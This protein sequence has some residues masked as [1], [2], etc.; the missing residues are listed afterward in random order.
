MLMRFLFY[1][2]AVAP[3][4]WPALPFD[5]CTKPARHRCGQDFAAESRLR[6]LRL[7]SAAVI[8]TSVF[9][10]QPV[11]CADKAGDD[12]NV[13]AGAYRSGRME[14]SAETFS[15]FLKDYPE[16][17]RAGIARLYFG[18]SLSSL[19]RYKE[20][21]EQF[22]TYISQQPRAP[23]VADARYRL[24]ECSYYL[25]DFA[26]AKTQL[27]EYLKEH[28]KHALHEWAMLFLA[29]SLQELGES[30]TASELLSQLLKDS[31]TTKLL[32]DAQFSLA[33][34]LESQQQQ[35]Q[36]VEVYRQISDDQASMLAPRALA[37]IGTIYFNRRQYEEASA[38]YDQV[39][40]RFADNPIAASAQFN[41]GLALF[42]AEKFDAAILRFDRLPQNSPSRPLALQLKAT[43]LLK[44]GRTDES[45]QALTDAVQAAGET[46]LATDL[47]I[48]LGQ[49]ERETKQYAAAAQVFEDIATR[50]PMDLRS[51]EALFNG[52]EL[53]LDL[54][55]VD[56]A[57]KLWRRL[58][59]GFSDQSKQNREQVL[60]GR[61]L[62][63]RG[64]RDGAISV[65]RG[66]VGDVALSADSPRPLFVGRYYLIRA[67][68]EAE[69]HSEVI[70]LARPAAVL[71]KE[72]NWRDLRGI[73]ALAA[74]SSLRQE[75]FADAV[76]FA[77]EFLGDESA[78]EQRAEVTA[79]RAVAQVRLM[80]YEQAMADI[81]ELS[82]KYADKAQSWTA[83]LQAA[84]AADQQG[85]LKESAQIFTVAAG[86]QLDPAVS[87][88]GFTGVA[89][90]YFKEKKF[91]EASTAFS[92][93]LTR[94]PDSKN[95]GQSL[96][97][98]ARC[99][100]EQGEREKAAEQ[101]R[102]V[103]QKLTADVPAAVAGAETSP[104]LQY[105]FDAGRQA[106]RIQ[107]SL[108]MLDGANQQWS[109]VAR[110]FPAAANLDR[111]L[112]EWA[113]LNL[114]AENFEKSD[115]IYR[116]LLDQFPSSAYA[117]QAR[118]SLAESQMQ[119]DN[120]DA[121]RKE[122]E[123]IVADPVYAD[124]EKERAQFHLLDIHTAQRS[125]S[126]VAAAAAHF[127]A[128][129]PESPLLPQAR[130][131][132]A[133]AALNTARTRTELET[134]E[135]SL[136]ALKD[137]VIAGTFPAEEWTERIWVVL[138]EIALTAGNYERI[139]GIAD[140]L[141][142]RKPDSRFAF[143]MFD[144]QGRRWKNQAAPD[145]EKS[146]EYFRRVIDDETGKGT[147]TAA[148]C[149]FL[150]AETLVMQNELAEARKE[151]FKVCLSYQFPELQA[152][153]LY[154]MAQCEF[155]LQ[156]KDD[157]VRSLQE[158]I[159]DYPQCPEAATAKQELTEL[160]IPVAP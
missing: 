144:I 86:N 38:V 136:S 156:K 160:G 53:R 129:F 59:A 7:L 73:L 5:S 159:R 21:R 108:K 24:G 58:E 20:A 96:Y 133:E 109:E 78:S 99:T 46:P 138:A 11:A 67:L 32:R 9:C 132:S 151:Y 81:K 121:A 139:D 91:A 27:S 131:L 112:D 130:L 135:V 84:E 4:I 37:R 128:T 49:L 93:L 94:F 80:H 34:S 148:R 149:Q 89:W 74:V 23:Q 47:M 92:E 8:L 69:R 125:W 90:S 72:P 157:A 154:Q 100:E 127:V 70:E 57:E 45:R 61:I 1:R 124:S 52:A 48:Q 88:A 44:T 65:L 12:F 71:L 97:M 134:V 16:H 120:L 6:M 117:G 25:K 55:E 114:N 107:G 147:E 3:F 158:L 43:S 31:P 126:E 35:D 54:K 14:L 98:A 75:Q 95:F 85:S 140:E 101:Y 15:R 68:Y 141:Q 150:I 29:D 77:D 30:Q 106:A 137:E 41:S 39:A 28:P 155:Q 145:F 146:R 118:L 103:F 122:F 63:A 17:P 66:V 10:G 13:A 42:R 40:E 152:Q 19:E 142:T 51:A 116:Q 115:Q 123:A 33:R 153:S 119:A 76:V 36:A 26:A 110:I 143:Q 79:V 83:I 113:W 56:S 104:P 60:L 50:W 22:L 62:L 102:A 2:T 105:A 64:D 82:E 87:E 111:V 18:L